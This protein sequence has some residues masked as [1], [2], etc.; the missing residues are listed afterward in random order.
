MYYN[1]PAVTTAASIAFSEDCSQSLHHTLV[2]AICQ[3]SG[4]FWNGL[5]TQPPS[6]TYHQVAVDDNDVLEV[7]ATGT[8]MVLTAGSS[9]QA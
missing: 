4:C 1:Q 9:D 5:A 2:G 7:P 6:L 8:V 3:T